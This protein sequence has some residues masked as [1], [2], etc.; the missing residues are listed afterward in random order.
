[1][2]AEGYCILV[3][4]FYGC[5]LDWSMPSYGSLVCLFGQCPSSSS[6]DDDVS[7]DLSI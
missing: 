2:H 1:M 3:K 5:W 6:D 7:D 4:S